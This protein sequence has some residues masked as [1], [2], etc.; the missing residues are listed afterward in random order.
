MSGAKSDLLRICPLY[1]L[2]RDVEAHAV[3]PAWLV[4]LAVLDI[5]SSVVFYQSSSNL[6]MKKQ[7]FYLECGTQMVGCQPLQPAFA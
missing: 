4:F 5:N 3:V 7:L 6:L 1:L 2:L